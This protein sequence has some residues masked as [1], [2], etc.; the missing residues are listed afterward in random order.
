MQERRIKEICQQYISTLH[1]NVE[2]INLALSEK[3]VYY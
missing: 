1:F 3:L 2:D